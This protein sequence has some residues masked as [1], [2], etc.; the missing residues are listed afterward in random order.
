MKNL[1]QFHAE[2]KFQLMAYSHIH[3]KIMGNIVANIDKKTEK[4]FAEIDKF[5]DSEKNRSCK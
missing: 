2:N 5:I 4:V 1:V 3:L